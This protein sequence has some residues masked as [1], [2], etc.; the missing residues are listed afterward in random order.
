MQCFQG[1]KHELPAKNI[2]SEVNKVSSAAV[3]SGRS[4]PFTVTSLVISTARD[5]YCCHHTRLGPGFTY[6][7]GG[8]TGGALTHLGKLVWCCVQKEVQFGKVGGEEKPN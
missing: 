7:G 5:V 2:V 6:A 1:A 8:M 3:V 4:V